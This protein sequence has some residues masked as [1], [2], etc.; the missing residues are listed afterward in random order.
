MLPFPETLLAPV[1]KFGLLGA[2]LAWSLWRQYKDQERLFRALENA[3]AALEKFTTKL[4]QLWE[5]R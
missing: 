5:S 3:T 1:A 2:V 4:D